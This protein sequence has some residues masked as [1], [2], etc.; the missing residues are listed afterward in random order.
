V[1]EILMA[2]HWSA[3]VAVTEKQAR[4]L[5][6]M[7]A[8]HGVCDGRTLLQLIDSGITP[9]QYA[10]MDGTETYRKLTSSS[11]IGRYGRLTIQ[12]LVDQAFE[13]YGRR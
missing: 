6:K 5:D 2:R 3:F 1:E 7:A 8:A 11:K 10:Q 9:E 13:Q 12:R 4:A